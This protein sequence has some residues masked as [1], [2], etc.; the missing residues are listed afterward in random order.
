MS[1]WL[2]VLSQADYD[3][4]L[5]EEYAKVDERLKEQSG[6]EATEGQ[7]FP[8]TQPVATRPG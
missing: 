7:E 1:G 2:Q 8:A 6:G 5:E 4:W 3:K